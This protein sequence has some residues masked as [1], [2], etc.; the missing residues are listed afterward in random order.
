MKYFLKLIFSR[1]EYDVVF[2]SSVVFNRGLESEN[3]LF[4]PMIDCCKKNN[5][6]YVI[7]EDT[8]LKGIYSNFNRSKEAI[9]FDFVSLIQIVLRKLF[10]LFSKAPTEI[11]EIYAREK[12]ISKILRIIFFNRFYSKVYI[13]LIWNNV[14]LWRSINN[15]ACII[16]YQHGVI[17]NGHEGYL[18]DGSPPKVKSLNKIDT[19]VYGNTFKKILMA[20]DKSNFYNEDNLI[21][22]GFNKTSG[23][24]K[25][26]PSLNK[27]ILFTLQITPDSISKAVNENYIKIV[28]NL[29][30]VN[31]DF[32]KTNNFKFI[33]RQHPRFSPDHCP[34]VNLEYDFISFDNFT[35]M[36]DLIDDV[37]MHITFNSTSV[38]EASMI[39]L[40][41]IFI[42]MHN[43]EFPKEINSNKVFSNDIFLNDYKYPYEHLF[44]KTYKDLENILVKLNDKTIYDDCCKN[45]YEWS[46]DL[47]SDFD[48]TAFEDFLLLKINT[49][50]KDA[51]S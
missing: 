35:P 40:P 18:I 19:M 50:N 12:K 27:K 43:Q 3:I 10:N 21:K 13:T 33:F 39:G 30:S 6:K 1:K 23:P 29:I 25:E 4:R 34:S 32:L 45:V 26:L 37:C 5:L 17:F 15:D 31:A 42:N 2:V 48:T 24:P 14:T 8:D 28:E 44:I 49:K 51:R 22:V 41:T 36:P 38:F 7:F 9:P 47:Y 20:N 46:K 11:N 16:D